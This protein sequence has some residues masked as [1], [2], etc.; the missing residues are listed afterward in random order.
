MRKILL[1]SILILIGF[2]CEKDDCCSANGIEGKWEW[3]QSVGGLGGWTQT[4]A[5]EG[6]TK[7]LIITET[8]YQ[9]CIE[10]N[11]VREEI[12]ILETRQD[13]FF[14]TNRFMIFNTGGERAIKLDGDQLEIHELCADCFSHTYTR[15]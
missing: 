3:I 10:G 6:V 12:Y 15:E 11:L 14:N 7:E 8:T 5:T 2:S 4:P 9:E 1:L 13:S